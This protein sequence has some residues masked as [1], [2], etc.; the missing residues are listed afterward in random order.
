MEVVDALSAIATQLDADRSVRS[1]I[2]TG[3]GERAFCVG[4]DINAW[5]V[6]EAL[7][8]WRMW[9]RRGHQVFDQWAQL[10]QPVIAAVNGHALGGGLELAAAADLRVTAAGAQFGLPQASLP[11]L[12]RRSGPQRLPRLVRGGR[13]EDLRLPGPRV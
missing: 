11:P 13:R 9:T 12:P 3:A 6:L 10:R 2:L 7:D 8:M 4:A 1:V 5:S